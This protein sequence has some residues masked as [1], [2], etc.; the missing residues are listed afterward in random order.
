MQWYVYVNDRKVVDDNRII[1]PRSKILLVNKNSKKPQLD[2]VLEEKEFIVLNKPHGLPTQKT[3]K[4]NEVNLYDQVRLFFILEKGFPSG[5][6]YVGLHHRLDRDTSGL[7]LMA[8]MRSVNKEI[9]DLFKNRQIT[10]VYRARTEWTQKR[11][12]AKWLEQNKILR[13]FHSKHRFYFKIS[14]GSGDT[15]ITEYQYVK[16]IEGEFHELLCFPKTG[17]THQLRVQLKNLGWP[18]LG[19]R[20]YGRKSTAQRMMLHAES[21]SF[22]LR[23]KEYRVEKKS[24]W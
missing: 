14:K 22:Y 7:V 12:P 11:P 8:K 4:R 9:A 19:D 23:G 18:I 16:S 6:P 10:K 15:A 3:L 2:I 1:R 13:G 5:L 24:A 17:R 20:V 21:L